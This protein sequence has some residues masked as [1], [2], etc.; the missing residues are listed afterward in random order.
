MEP[1]DFLGAMTSWAMSTLKCPQEVHQHSPAWLKRLGTT[2]GCCLFRLTIDRLIT[3]AAGKTWRG[4]EQ[5]AP[6]QIMRI[7]WHCQA[8]Q[9][10]KVQCSVWPLRNALSHSSAKFDP[11]GQQSTMLPQVFHQCTLIGGQS[12]HQF[13]RYGNNHPA[14][15]SDHISLWHPS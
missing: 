15:S 1:Y 6:P 4:R 11:R 9:K 7:E 2:F 14:T 12:N 13:A 5:E 3:I 10:S 8:P